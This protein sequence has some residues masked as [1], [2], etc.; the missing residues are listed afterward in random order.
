VIRVGSRRCSG[1]VGRCLEQQVKSSA[2]SK[3]APGSAWRQQQ[4]QRKVG[5]GG[6]SSARRS[7]SSHAELTSQLN[8][9]CCL[10]SVAPVFCYLGASGPAVAHPQQCLALE[11]REWM[12]AH[13]LKQYF[14]DRSFYQLQAGAIV[15]NPDQR[16]AS[17]VR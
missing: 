7:T 9:C 6:G 4:Q 3:A 14:A 12:T 1:Y 16:I 5:V 11:W 13:L 10:L 2:A 15:D 8:D 17:D